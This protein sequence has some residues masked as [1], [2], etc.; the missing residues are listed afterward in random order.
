M[1]G[2]QKPWRD[3]R[4][5]KPLAVRTVPCQLCRMVIEVRGRKSRVDDFVLEIEADAFRIIDESRDLDV[6]QRP[7]DLAVAKAHACLSARLRK[8]GAPRTCPLSR[9]YRHVRPRHGLVLR[10]VASGA[11]TQK[12]ILRLREAFGG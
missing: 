7:Q 2:A 6:G 8:E 3:H 4:R 11:T 1:M 10:Y 12:A 5:L 9:H